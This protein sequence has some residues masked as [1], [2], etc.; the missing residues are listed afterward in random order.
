MAV[1]VEQGTGVVAEGCL[2]SEDFGG[3]SKNFLL[4]YVRRVDNS[5]RIGYT[6]YGGIATS[7]RFG[8]FAAESY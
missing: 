8:R 6:I 5:A 7:E 4:N 3:F 2:G 1:L